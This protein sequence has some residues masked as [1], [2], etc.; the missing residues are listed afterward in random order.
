MT[1]FCR[2]PALPGVSHCAARLCA[3]RPGRLRAKTS[4]P[5]MRKRAKSSGGAHICR[6]SIKRH[7]GI[8]RQMNV[9]RRDV[10]PR[11]RKRRGAGDKYERHIL[12]AHSPCLRLALRVSIS[13]LS[14]E[15]APAPLWSR[16]LL[17]FLNACRRVIAAEVFLPILGKGGALNLKTTRAGPN[18]VALE[19]RVLSEE[20]VTQLA[21]GCV[22]DARLRAKCEDITRLRDLLVHLAVLLSHCCRVNVLRGFQRT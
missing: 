1:R 16:L 19:D 15:P 8:I 14:R 7:D 10:L 13:A 17:V 5:S 2:D 18:F 4:H 22:I 9:S 6:D 11:V 12:R 20:R 3:A 21:N